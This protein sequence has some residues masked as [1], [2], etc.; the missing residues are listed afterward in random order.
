MKTQTNVITI[1]TTTAQNGAITNGIRETRE[2]VNLYEFRELPEDVQNRILNKYMETRTEWLSIDFC[3]Y[4]EHDIWECVRDLE[5]SITGARVRWD[6]NH[7]Y[8]CDFDTEYAYDDCYDPCELEIIEDNGY[9][10]SMDICDSWNAHIKKLNAIYARFELIEQYINETASNYDYW[11]LYTAADRVYNRL[12]DMRSDLIGRWYAE[13][14]NACKD[15]SNTITSLLITE[16]ED[17]QTREYALNEYLANECGYESR[18][19]DNSGRVYYYDSRQWFTIDG[20]KYET[21][22]YRRE[23]VSIVKR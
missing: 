11:N 14:E 15:V 21:P 22:N 17:V 18:T 20:E 4:Q 23:C 1:E 10:A 5:K 3:N 2:T 12:D 7:W 13:L 19:I 8:S 16:W 9:Y 6:Y